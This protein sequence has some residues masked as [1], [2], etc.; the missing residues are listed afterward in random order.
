[1]LAVPER[2]ASTGQVVRGKLHDDAVARKDADVILAH[3][4]AKVPEHLM[5]VLQL[6]GELGVRQGFL[7]DAFDRDRVRVCPARP[8]R[9]IGAGNRLDATASA[10]L[11]LCL[12]LL[13]QTLLLYMA[14]SV[15]PGP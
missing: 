9:R 8:G 2:N 14:Q 13:N 4:A 10:S 7:H 5:A 1:R 6:D 3:A 15:V 11:L 12:I